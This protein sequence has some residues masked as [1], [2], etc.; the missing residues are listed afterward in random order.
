M[1]RA[2]RGLAERGYQ[3]AVIYDVGAADGAWTRLA[4]TVWPNAKFVCFEPLQEREEAL[5][6]LAQDLPGRVQTLRIGVVARGDDFGVIRTVFADMPYRC[7]QI[8]DDAHGQDQI[9]EL[10]LSPRE[11]ARRFSG[12]VLE[13]AGDALEGAIADFFPRSRIA[14]ALRDNLPKLWKKAEDQMIRRIETAMDSPFP[15]SPSAT[16]S[17]A[18]AG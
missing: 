2:L 10:A 1:E 13:A 7:V 5:N 12:D 17:P 3:P 8:V 11:F 9:K 14:Q 16:T 4:A 6:G 15:D 18:S